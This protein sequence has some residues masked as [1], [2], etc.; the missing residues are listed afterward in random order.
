MSFANQERRALGRKRYLEIQ[1]SDMIHNVYIFY[2]AHCEAIVAQGERT[3]LFSRTKEQDHA[4]GPH[5]H[6][7]DSPG[8]CPEPG[9]PFA[10]KFFLGRFSLERAGK[11]RPDLDPD[12][13]DVM[14]AVPGILLEASG[15]EE[16]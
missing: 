8:S 9:A 12:T 4:D 7:E 10:R 1:H 15:G 6:A 13:A 14:E 2:L 5:E 16:S 11:N 3:H